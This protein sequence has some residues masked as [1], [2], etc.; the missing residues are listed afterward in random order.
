MKNIE[1]Y[2][3][4]PRIVYG[5][6][7]L[8]EPLFGP[9]NGFN[10][11]Y[12]FRNLEDNLLTPFTNYKDTLKSARDYSTETNFCDLIGFGKIKLK[13]AEHKEEVDN[14][15]RGTD[16]V[17]ISK[18][19]QFGKLQFEL[20]GPI[21]EGKQ[22]LEPILGAKL[23]WTDFTTF[24]FKNSLEMT[25]FERAIYLSSEVIRQGGCGS[26]IGEFHLRRFKRIIHRP[27]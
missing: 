17:V 3:F 1:G 15:E 21:V 18:D 11:D 25:P 7:G 27:K 26:T 5:R 16:L 14:F 13:I 10:R 22:T 23:S 9:S 4:I 6:G 24:N 19:N 8:N 2:V 20:Y 12:S